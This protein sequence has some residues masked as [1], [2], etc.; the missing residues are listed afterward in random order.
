MN[1]QRSITRPRTWQSCWAWDGEGARDV[2]EPAFLTLGRGKYTCSFPLV[3]AGTR[4]QV[5]LDFFHKLLNVTWEKEILLLSLL[6]QGGL[7]WP[8]LVGQYHNVKRKKMKFREWRWLAQS[9]TF[10]SDNHIHHTGQ[11]RL[12]YQIVPRSSLWLQLPWCCVWVQDKTG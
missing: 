2:E 4:Q 10:F 3:G 1:I 9:H 12:H 6:V 11:K 8:R 7:C 5:Y